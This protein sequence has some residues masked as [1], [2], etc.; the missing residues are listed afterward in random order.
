M[1]Y[2]VR[3]VLTYNNKSGNRGSQGPYRISDTGLIWIWPR[4]KAAGVEMHEPEERVPDLTSDIQGDPHSGTADPRMGTA[5]YGGIPTHKGEWL[6]AGNSNHDRL[7]FDTF[8]GHN[9]DSNNIVYAPAP[10]PLGTGFTPDNPRMGGISISKDHVAIN[11]E[12]R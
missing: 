1:G 7:A 12:I 9:G 11:N 6:D 8:V 4:S 2:D 10:I 3:A 5:G